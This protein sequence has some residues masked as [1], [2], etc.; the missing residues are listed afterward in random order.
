MR[1]Q[2]LTLEN[3]AAAALTGRKTDLRV[4]VEQQPVVHQDAPFVGPGE[5]RDAVQAEALSCAARSEQYRD[6]RVT[7]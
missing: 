4:G 6:F 3:A 1:E 5:T 2:R 7:L